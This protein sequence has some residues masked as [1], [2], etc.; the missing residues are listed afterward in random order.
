MSLSNNQAEEIIISYLN[1]H[2]DEM[3]REVSELVQINTVNP[4]AGDSTAKSEREG[5]IY[6]KKK[7]EAIGGRSFFVPVPEDIYYRTNFLG[8]KNRSF[9]GR[10]NLVGEFIFNSPQKS[11]IINSHIDTVGA[12]EMVIEPF[13]GEV[14]DGKIFGR[15]ATDSKGGLIS[16]LFAIRA[17]MEV[18]ENL[19]G[20]IIFESVI[21]EE[22][23]G[24]GAGTLALCL[25]GYKAD[26]AIVVDGSGNQI[27]YG[28]S[29]VLTSRIKVFGRGGHSSYKEGINAIDK[30]IIIK[31]AFDKFKKRRL[32]KYPE[33]SSNIGVFQ[34]GS[35]PALIPGEA[36]LAMNIGY[37]VKEA[38]E[39]QKKFGEWGGRVVREEFERLLEE[40]QSEDAWLKEHPVEITW[41]KDLYPYLL[42][43]E[44]PIVKSLSENYKKILQREPECT[45]GTAWYDAAHLWRQAGIPVVSFGPGKPHTAH[46][47]EEYIEI[48]TLLAHAKILALTLYELLQKK[49]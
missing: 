44:L 18:R 6:L 19:E 9:K 45:C 46:S 26:W 39:S 43:K 32:V 20:K 7:C 17:I 8:P 34:A 49:S 27:L 36:L 13:S 14:K 47:Q 12:A 30:A 41:L 25:A 28:C 15:G 5:Q 10:E 22:C 48:E 2:C 3:V 42:D 31:D 38:E 35:I 24:G 11:V 4:Y 1:T 16:A 23:D 37:S 29:G 40:R 21:D 33:L